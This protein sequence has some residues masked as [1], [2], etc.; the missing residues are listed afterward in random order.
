MFMN[1]YFFELQYLIYDNV[2]YIQRQT[3]QKKSAEYSEEGEICND[4]SCLVQYVY[5]AVS[6]LIVHCNLKCD[7]SHVRNFTCY[8]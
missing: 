6:R 7:E 2:E 1:G 8:I 3:I 5:T 4:V